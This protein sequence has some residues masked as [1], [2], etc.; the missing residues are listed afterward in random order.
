[1]RL[2]KYSR[3]KMYTATTLLAFIITAFIGIIIVS[4]NQDKYFDVV[5]DYIEEETGIG[6]SISSIK[7]RSPFIVRVND[8]KLYSKESDN[9]FIAISESSFIINPFRILIK[10]DPLYLVSIIKVNDAFL[11]PYYI[12]NS[13]FKSNN[14]EADISDKK[15]ELNDLFKILIDKKLTINNFRIS[16]SESGGEAS[17]P[18]EAVFTLF[19]ING[20]SDKYL[21]N[22]TVSLPSDTFIT[23]A[24]ESEQNLNN[25][26]LNLRAYDNNTSL[27]DYQ[28]KTELNDRDFI[29]TIKDKVKKEY[30]GE[31]IYNIDTDDT[32]FSI[33]NVYINKQTLNKIYDI[34]EASSLLENVLESDN[35]SQANALNYVLESFIET[36]LSLEGSYKKDSPLSL[37]FNINTK[38]EDFGIEA[39]GGLTNKKLYIN[40]AII[41]TE[42]G[43]ILGKGYI[44]IDEPLASEFSIVTDDLLVLN[45]VLNI[46]I[47]IKPLSSS[48]N[49]VRSII[50]LNQLKYKEDL[51]KKLSYSLS[52]NK[53]NEVL[54]IN[55]ITDNKSDSLRA[56]VY[57]NSKSEDIV[58]VN[59]TVPQSLFIALAG[60]G[61]IDP[62][63]DIE[64]DYTLSR[65]KEVKE[66]NTHNITLIT[67][68][69]YT[70]DHEF[71]LNAILNKNNI[72]IKDLLYAGMSIYGE[73]DYDND[74]NNIDL[75]ANVESP[76]GK[77]FVSGEMKKNS[78]GDRI[79]YASADDEK[80]V[81]QGRINDNGEYNF[82]LSTTEDIE[83]D[84][85][86][87]GTKI[88]LNNTDKP[89][90]EIY[91]NGV[92]TAKN[93]NLPIFSANAGFEMSNKTIAFTNII[94]DYGI[95]TLSGTG[96]LYTEDTALKFDTILNDRY[97][98]GIL[99]AELELNANNMYA[100]V[101]VKDIPLYLNIAN[102]M[103]GNVSTKITVIGNIKDPVMY[104]DEVKINNFEVLGHIADVSLTGYYRKK[105][106]ELKNILVNF[107]G[108]NGIYYPVTERP[109]I[110]VPKAY[111]SEDLHSA[112]V[113]IKNVEYLSTYNGEIDYNMRVL[114]NG[115]TEYRLKTSKIG[116]NKRRLQEFST[117]VI[118][119]GENISFINQSSHGI[120]GFINTS[121][122]ILFSD[123]K[124][125][126]DNE[127]LLNITGTVTHGKES[128]VDMLLTSKVLNL[129]I[130]E[131]YNDIFSSIEAEK[132]KP[133][134]FTVDREQYVL[135]TKLG[136]T[137]D[138]VT[139]TGRLVGNARRV[140]TPFFSDVFT[141]GNVDFIFEGNSARITKL[142]FFTKNGKSLVLTGDAELTHNFVNYINFDLTTSD[143]SEGFLNA[144]ANLQV[145]KAKGPTYVELNIGGDL[146]NVLMTGKAVLKDTHI[147]ITIKPENRYTPKTF[148]KA[149][150]IYWDFSVDAM[151]RV[152]VSHN[153]VGDFSLVD[154]GKIRIYDSVKDGMKVEGSVDISRGNIYY[155]QNV[156]T[157]ERGNV[158]FP[159]DNS[160]DPI[161]NATAYTHTKYYSYSSLTSVDPDIGSYDVTLYMEINAR[162]SQLLFNVTGGIT[163]IKFYTIPALGQYQVNQ[164]AG[165]IQNG[166]SEDIGSQIYAETTSS[167]IASLEADSDKI[168][169][170][171]MSYG[172]LALRNTLLRPVER[173]IRQFLGIDYINL[174]P[175]VI[176]NLIDI[177]NDLTTAS[178]FDN[179]SVSIG[180][181]VSKNLFIK[182][183]VT[184]KFNDLTKLNT[185]SETKDHYYF[186]HQFGFEVSLLN[187]LRVANLVFEYK[188]NPFE[189]DNIN[190]IGQEFN[191][192]TR[193]RF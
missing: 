52:Y 77:Y 56:S 138:N 176:G 25:L 47:N 130:F 36:S 26:D 190:S 101:V 55:S 111:F 129:E 92:I 107:K 131:I 86:Y 152:N 151:Q 137:T 103:Y 161:I 118:D 57:M 27:F 4:V 117:I 61:I 148:S 156:Y 147:E 48:K 8:L 171:V 63:S 75:I 184:Y 53:K 119:S 104:L 155:L 93:N 89:D 19:E 135:Y 40:N 153:L 59:G 179:T 112:K 145:I 6:I 120:K 9:P 21:I 193:W 80:I 69:I 54:N 174:N 34:V 58:S 142:D 185:I 140:E 29:L 7:L 116:I 188:I 18:V 123:L 125:I 5:I 46:D 134:K 167:S 168:Q 76:I 49:N 68:K 91:L 122:N 44:P 183:D 50:T 109:S 99:A 144:N 70:E 141:T 72:L 10:R 41:K 143:A 192:I 160:L 67:K 191:L 108:I 94:Y 78:D 33:T 180:K 23:L 31:F 88:E 95:N 22:S 115:N 173:W 71:Y 16:L 60:Y 121:G 43:N 106:M 42:I 98:D 97:T 82:I 102:G 181:Y 11:Y 85:I 154:G 124:Y 15:K 79:L 13:M 38:D 87:F 158:T 90:N 45:E 159:T 166:T 39:N 139:I 178:V 105:E 110:K 14:D 28:A 35:D 2:R 81:A 64:I 162:I 32:K 96:N 24:M 66:E 3:L 51:D 170:L 136:G 175:A 165:V 169:Q 114:G 17:K 100:T 37:S 20:N 146:S 30:T 172:D 149:S 128:V 163:P 150:Q 177:D 132:S 133:A 84:G 189:V 127:D 186:D 83:F 113:E 187:H 62:L 73:I 157:V 126:Y 65:S 182:Y 1:M 164:L 12:D 74:F